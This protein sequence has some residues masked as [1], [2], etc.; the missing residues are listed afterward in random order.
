MKP[1][2]APTP[3]RIMQFAWG[4]V[5]LLLIATAIRHK[6]FDHLDSGPKKFTELVKLT[7]TSERGLRALAN[8][9]VGIQLLN[10]SGEEYSLG[11]D[12]AI[13]LVSTKPS[14]HGLLFLHF[15]KQLLPKWLDLDKIV[16]TGK[17]AQTVNMETEGAA[18]FAEFVE[19][20]FP[21]S[22]PAAKTLGE[23]LQ[24][25]QSKPGTTVLDLAAGSGVWG[26]ALAQQ[27]PNVNIHAVDWPPVL[28][29]TKKVADRHGVGNRLTAVEGD[30]TSADFGSGHRVATLG[31]ILHSEGRERS[32]Q[33]LRKTFAALASGGT[34]AI[35]EFLVNNDRTGPPS[36]LFFAV[37]MLVNTVDGDA[38]SFEEISDW[39]L[40]AGFKD[41]RL[42]EVPAVSP[43]VLATKP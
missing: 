28:K 43:L 40:E 39:L 27:S 2:A 35:M 21:L 9:L 6:L 4:Y 25:A 32:R 42:L 8:G 20:L 16:T 14:F 19:S 29:V 34:I 7:G 17:P 18:F 37:N 22:Y 31:H 1:D 41:P 30:L 5:P 11:P 24:M 10:K 3:E 26:I 23:H 33:L 13:F 15:V 38:F 36:G 12:A